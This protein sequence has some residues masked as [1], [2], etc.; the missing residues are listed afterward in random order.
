M[1][2]IFN[3]IANHTSQKA[4]A[5][6]TMPNRSSPSREAKTTI[7]NVILNISSSVEPSICKASGAIEHPDLPLDTILLA[8]SH[9]TKLTPVYYILYKKSKSSNKSTNANPEAFH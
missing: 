1:P 6:C 8:V 7:Q 9:D 4:S 3:F 2:T 5:Y